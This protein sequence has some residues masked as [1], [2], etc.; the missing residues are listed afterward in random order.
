MQRGE[1]VH[2]R[3][4]DRHV[5]PRHRA[6]QHDG[7]RAVDDR[8]DRERADHADRNVELRILALLGGRRRRIEADVAEEDV[9]ADRDD[10][11]GLRR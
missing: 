10:A 6:D 3:I 9:R 5:I 1:R 2:E 4:L 11:V 8:P 7:G